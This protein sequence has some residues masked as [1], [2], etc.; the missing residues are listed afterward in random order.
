MYKSKQTC[1]N[2][3]N[4]LNAFC[5]VFIYA[6]FSQMDAVVESSSLFLLPLGFFK[7]GQGK[8]N[9]FTTTNSSESNNLL[10]CVIQTLNVNNSADI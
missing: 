8:I 5:R 2:I 1:R 6:L 7:K 10:K 9:F 3:S 4:S